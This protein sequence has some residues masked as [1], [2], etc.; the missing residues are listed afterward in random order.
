LAL[1]EGKQRKKTLSGIGPGICIRSGFLR[2]SDCIVFFDF[3]NT[4]TPFDVL[5]DLVKRFSINQRW[6][7]F[8]REWKDGKISSR[9]CLAE[10][11][12]RVRITR[13]ELLK[14]ISTIR[15]D[16]NFTKLHK[17]LKK[18]GL[19]LNIL[20]DSFTFLIRNILRNNGIK[21]AKMYAN[22]LK[23]SKDRLI[24]SFPRGSKR[25]LRCAHCKKNNLL[26]KGIKNKIIMYVGDGL[27]DVC[28][29]EYSD[30]VFAKGSLLRHFRRKNLLCVSYRSML[31][32]Y[33]HF[34][35]LEK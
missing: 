13:P 11:L 10:Q 28:P 4:I 1:Q 25:C 20:S 8:E 12:R 32:I 9:R 3:D 23:F 29:A 34:K 17:L 35:G 18:E 27:S 2:L 30:I 7:F 6:K 16:P 5:D 15:I 21:D 33:R 26:K 19:E 14:Y 31:D 24:P 22:R